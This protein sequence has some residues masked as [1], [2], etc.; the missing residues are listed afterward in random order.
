MTLSVINGSVVVLIVINAECRKQTHY[1]VC[2]YAE[3]RYAEC[4]YAECRGD[5]ET[6]NH[7]HP[8]LMFES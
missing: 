1:A 6:D 5:V 2:R 4:R 3:C 7:F 8:R